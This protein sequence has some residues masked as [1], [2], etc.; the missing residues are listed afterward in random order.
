M[1]NLTNSLYSQERQPE[2]NS[3]VDS[4]IPSEMLQKLKPGQ[5]KNK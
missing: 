3:K 1:M 5:D 2:T 4:L